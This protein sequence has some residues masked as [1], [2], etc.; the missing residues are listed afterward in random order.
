MLK[1]TIH[2]FSRISAPFIAVLPGPFEEVVADRAEDKDDDFVVL[3]DEEEEHGVETVSR[4]KNLM[5]L[6]FLLTAVETGLEFAEELAAVRATM[7]D[8]AFLSFRCWAVV[9]LCA[10][11]FPATVVELLLLAALL[12]LPLPLLLAAAFVRTLPDL[13]LI[14]L[15]NSSSSS[16]LCTTSS[17]D[18]SS[19]SLMVS[20]SSSENST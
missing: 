8:V 9:D 14:G 19:G 2:F 20:D 12:P 18:T 15:S 17:S 3:V 16:V 5:L 1:K 11:S 6:A 10:R 4:G 13:V 7:G